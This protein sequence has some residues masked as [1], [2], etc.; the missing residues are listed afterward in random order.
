MAKR[1]KPEPQ[2]IGG[3]T[4][5][6]RP[7]HAAAPRGKIVEPGVGWAWGFKMLMDG[8]CPYCKHALINVSIRGG[9]LSWACLDGC[10]P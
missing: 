5:K 9:Q 4:A 2:L 3:G 8:F 7:S 10:N 6:K 1:N